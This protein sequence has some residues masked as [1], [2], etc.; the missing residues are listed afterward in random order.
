MLNYIVRRVLYM[1]PIMLGI[2][3]VVFILF[4]LVGGD[5]VLVMLGK[6]VNQQAIDDLR[7][8]LGLNKPL[9]MQFFDFLK[10]IVTMD[11]GRSYSTKQ[12]IFQMMRDTAPVSFVV[13][14]PA[15]V[16]SVIMAIA[17]ALFVAF[18]RGSWI[19]RF[20]VVGCVMLISIPSLAYILF[21]QYLLAYQYGWFPISGF[22]WGFP[23][24]LSY[25]GLPTL[26]LIALS[27]GG[28]LRFYRTIMLDEVYQDYIRTARS[29]GLSERVVMF[30]HVLK[31]AMIPIITTV[32]IEI[33]FLITGSL[34]VESFFGLPGMGSMIVD[35][36]N[37]SDFPVLKAS[38]VVLSIFYMIANLVSDIL[39]SLV[40]P[41]ITLK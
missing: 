15:F 27:L 39:Y 32:V 35:A 18:W 38:V 9:Y 24:T 5:P 22:S 37:T 8:E 19:D 31:N 25:I 7:A 40:D 2:A 17:L 10:Q 20:I 33:P 26:I 41:R 21:G 3:L 6:H 16:I 28:E 29:K 4:N 30:K 1:I 11:F 34:L 13:A 36:L 23:D 12:D 14:F